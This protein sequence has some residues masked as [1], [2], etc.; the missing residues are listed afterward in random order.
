MR[1]K[2]QGES[3]GKSG[4]CL[5]GLSRDPNYRI[6]YVQC[7]LNSETD[8]DLTRCENLIHWMSVANNCKDNL[9]EQN[10]IAFCKEI[11]H[12]KNSNEKNIN[13]NITN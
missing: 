5:E 6:G 1:R 7:E 10:G 13:E 8:I 4:H 3:E 9:K 11:R 12:P 2:C